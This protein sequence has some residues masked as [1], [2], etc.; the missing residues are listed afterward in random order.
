MLE[1]HDPDAA[2]SF[3]AFTL[4]P[5]LGDEVGVRGC[6]FMIVLIM[7]M[8]TF[9]VIV[10]VMVMVMVVIVACVAVSF[11]CVITVSRPVRDAAI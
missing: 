6:C 1:Q 3:A 4:K 9:M 8:V 10:M 11:F 2:R 5:I 7:F